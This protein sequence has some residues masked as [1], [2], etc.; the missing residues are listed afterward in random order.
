MRI[1]SGDYRTYEA[2]AGVAVRTGT[3]PY[4]IKIHPSACQ[5]GVGARAGLKDLGFR[6]LGFRV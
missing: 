6:V 2:P 3:V 4:F 5:E 1:E